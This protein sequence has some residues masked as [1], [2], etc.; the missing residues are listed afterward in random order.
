MKRRVVLTKMAS[1]VLMLEFFEILKIEN[2]I[3]QTK[4]E[5]FKDKIQKSW[6]KLVAKWKQVDKNPTQ[7]EHASASSAS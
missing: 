1:K 4:S 7:N 6:E 2:A 5:K 3:W